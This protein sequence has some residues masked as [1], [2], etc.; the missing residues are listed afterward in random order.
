MN[1]VLA[2]DS[3]KGSLSSAAVCDI[4]K[5]AF[6]AEYE[7]ANVVS[8][9]MA[10]GGEGTLEAI[11]TA[12][13]GT[14]V[15]VEAKG[16]LF[17][18]RQTVY[19]VVNGDTVIVETASI[20]GLTL[21]PNEKRNP[22]CTTTYGM[23]EVI[24]AALDAGYRRFLVALGGSATNDGGFG[25]LSALGVTFTNEKGER[26]PP[27]AASLADIA[28]VDFATIDARV[29]ESTFLVAS[30]VTNPL[31]GKN[32]ASFVFGPQKGANAEQ[33]R[34]LDNALSNYAAKIEA[35]LRQAY[36]HE[37]GAGAAGGLGFAF[38]TLGG[39]IVSGAELVAQTV[40]LEEKIKDAHF[41]M[42]GEGRSDEQTLYGKVPLYVA[43]LARK[44]GA[45]PILLS[46]SLGAGFERLYDY[47][48]SCDAIA[49]GPMTVDECMERAEE[50]LYI[51]AR[52]VA[53][54]LKTIRKEVSE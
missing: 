8:V 48:I 51:K 31:C 32:G 6:A 39:K 29:Y 28:H 36:Q 4:I 5:R 53:R 3:F 25:L 41:V 49:T 40:R 15:T 9:P 27:F 33:V 30:D 24:R 46:G 7:E 18:K 47:F 22:L 13:N 38:L 1:I 2:P 45:K 14:T 35:H 11:V 54:L 50:L 37:K 20:A 10:D 52:N 19:G 16:P 17:E 43:T 23:G 44:H 26:L 12:T 21:V 34:F 42:T